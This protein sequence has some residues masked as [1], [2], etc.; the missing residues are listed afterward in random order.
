MS[1]KTTHRKP[2]NIMGKT[3]QN[4][5]LLLAVAV[6]VIAMAAFFMIHAVFTPPAT[7]GAK[8]VTIEVVDNEEVST[9]YELHTDALYLRQALEE[10]E[11]LTFSGTEGSYGLM[12]ET[13]NDCTADWDKDHAWWSVYVNGE[14]ANYGVDQQ[15]VNDGDVFCLQYTTEANA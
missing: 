9:S 2:R 8:T 10:A 1:Y 12:I 15:P 5:T 13:V 11:G 14:L 7:E 3:K 4:K 6:L